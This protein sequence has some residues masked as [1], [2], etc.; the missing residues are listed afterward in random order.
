M[1]RRRVNFLFYKVLSSVNEQLLNVVNTIVLL[2]VFN[3]ILHA[4][5]RFFV[6]GRSEH[7]Q[8][9]SLSIQIPKSAD[10][11]MKEKLWE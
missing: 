6:L 8:G 1:A 5:G 11:G 3:M 4:L 7:P 9:S 2:C 10:F